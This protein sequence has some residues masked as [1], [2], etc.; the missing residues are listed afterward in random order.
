MPVHDKPLMLRVAAP[1]MAPQ[2]VDREAGVIHGFSVITVGEALGHGLWIDQAML[3]QVADQGNAKGAGLK[4]RFTHPGLSGDGMGKQVGRAKNFRV[5]GEQ[6]LADLHLYTQANQEQVESV[7]DLAEEDAAAFGMSIVFKQDKEA[8]AAFMSANAGEDK[9]F[10]SPDKRNSKNLTH[11]RVAALH[12]VDA[13]DDP[14]ANPAGLFSEGSELP[15][16]AEVLLSYALGLSE[17]CPDEVAAGPHPERARAFVAGFLE[18]HGLAIVKKEKDANPEIGVPSEDFGA[19]RAAVE[20]LRAELNTM[21]AKHEQLK[22]FVLAK[23][24]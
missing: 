10:K 17:A 1:K 12:A 4:S 5:E 14:A 18:R 3:Q 9:K 7:L 24:G 23:K 22:R 20:Q 11:A 16:R 15:A 8:Q 2:Q 6:V 19:L 21:S 13:V